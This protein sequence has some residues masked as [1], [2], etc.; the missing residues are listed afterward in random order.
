MGYDE[1]KRQRYLSCRSCGFT[2][3]EA[4]ELA[5]VTPRTIRNWRK[6]DP[7]FKATDE[8]N[9]YELYKEQGLENITHAFMRNMKL[10]KDW[11]YRLVN[12]SINNPDEMTE[13]ESKAL[14]D[15]RGSYTLDKMP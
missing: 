14:L 9:V 15:V 5:H 10:I 2:R 1:T 11:E 13:A 4:A 6:A 3:R 12:K 7:E 8:K